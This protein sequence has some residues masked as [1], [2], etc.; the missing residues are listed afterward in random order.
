[1]NSRKEVEYWHNEKKK[2]W[3]VSAELMAKYLDGTHTRKDSDGTL[4]WEKNDLLHRGRDKPAVIYANGTLIWWQNDQIHRD[5]DRPAVILADGGLSWWQNGNQHRSCGPA[6][7][8]TEGQ[9]EWWINDEDITRE[10]RVWLAR[11]RWRSTPEQIAEFKLRF[12]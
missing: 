12:A 11:K 10:V 3:P 9:R 4:H 2:Y 8:K 7:I 5:G 1:M 6:K